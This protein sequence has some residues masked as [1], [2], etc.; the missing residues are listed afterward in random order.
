MQN[1]LQVS[2]LERKRDWRSLTI[3]M[4]ISLFA[5]ALLI[6]LE[7][8]SGHLS[9]QGLEGL[10]GLAIGSAIAIF[11]LPLLAWPFFSSRV[12]LVVLFCSVAI[13]I[14]PRL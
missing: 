7:R 3:S 4:L 12:T 13:Q 9:G 10:S 5:G 2:W 6:Y 8:A 1:G 11:L 14:A